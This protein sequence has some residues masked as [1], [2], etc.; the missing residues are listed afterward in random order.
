MDIQV[1]ESTD[2]AIWEAANI[3]E[4]LI[5]NAGSVLGLA[6]GAT[7]KPL[8]SE[9]AR[10]RRTLAPTIT[11]LHAFL[12]DEYIG[13]APEDSRC[14]RNTIISDFA[15]QVGLPEEN[16]Q[17]PQTARQDLHKECCRYET[18]LSAAEVAIQLL[19]I[20][21]NGHIGFNEP[22]SMFD[23]KTRVVELSEQTRQA[24]AH[25][26]APDPMP[27]HAITQG[28]STILKAKHLLVLAFGSSKALPI[29][30]ALKGPITTKVP[31]SA[32]RNHSKVTVLLDAEAASLLPGC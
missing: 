20:G 4:D 17:S 8:Y 7:M 21:V 9:L 14:F 13:L 15:S 19:G 5:L 12:L 27:T 1:F 24:N 2:A 23:S 10:R 30:Q 32:I 3:V 28:I 25:I 26:F 29:Q 31:A 16:I 18:S 22:G 11:E 6:A